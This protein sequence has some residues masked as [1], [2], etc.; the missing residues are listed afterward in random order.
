MTPEDYW[1][2]AHA[3]NSLT[4]LGRG[5]VENQ[6]DYWSRVGPFLEDL[7]SAASVLDVGPGLGRYLAAQEGKDRYAIDVS[8]VSRLRM[9]DMGVAAY[10][11]GD[12]GGFDIDLATCLSVV[13]HCDKRAVEI[14]L[15]D[16]ARALRVRGRFYVNGLDVGHDNSGDPAVLMR[17]ARFSYKV[18]AMCAMADDYGFAVVNEHSYGHGSFSVWILC[19]EKQRAVAQS[20]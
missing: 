10:A 19:L 4:Q 11:P 2:K 14:I 1:D 18:A 20:G 6:Y 7:D 9:R 16:V 15:S 5:S 17:R 12:I 13:Q 8:E 3:Q